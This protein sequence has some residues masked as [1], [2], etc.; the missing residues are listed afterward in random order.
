MIKPTIKSIADGVRLCSLK[1]SQF[2]TG[3]I[4]IT[5]ALPLNENASANAVLPFILHRSCKDYPDFT[6]LNG[7][8]AELYGAILCANV[9]KHGEAQL[10]SVS[11]TAIDDRFSLTDESIAQECAWLLTKIIF[12]PKISDGCFEKADVEREKR[13]LIEKLEGEMDNKG[14]YAQQR[15]EQVM[16]ENEAF[17]IPK[18]GMKEKISALT[19]EDI[20][21]A[22]Q[23]V[24]K[25]AVILITVIS[26]GESDAIEQSFVKGFSAIKRSCAK[27]NTVFIKAAKEPKRVNEQ[28]SVKQG[29]LVLGFR[30][31]MESP[32][33][34][35]Y[36]MYVAA[37]I[38][39]G[40]TYSKL[41][42]NVR[43]KMSLCYY[44][45]AILHRQKGVIF[46]RS[47]IETENEK[48]ATD[49]ILRQLQQIQQGNVSQDEFNASILAVCDRINGYN[50]SP[51]T[52]CAWYFSQIFEDD[53]RTPEFYVEKYKAVTLDGVI[54]AAKGIT[55][56]T[57]FMLSSKPGLGEG[58][59]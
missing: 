46:V 54:N 35:K 48:K 49:E 42:S 43:E 52:I 15:C 25:T 58:Q 10:L 55:L 34:K 40:G 4:M 38:F 29:K 27:P 26:S 16:C 24:L 9:S 13:L 12:E 20:Y 21:D 56:D 7:R 3:K 14:V 59:E 8:L 30:A 32:D 2:K 19:P 28:Q 57:V 51:E 6:A 22:W 36:D 41:F 23:R 17:G 47:G 1:T 37:D 44:C 45:H 33:D 50:D 53:I 31:G 5:M 18:Y 39:G 11:L